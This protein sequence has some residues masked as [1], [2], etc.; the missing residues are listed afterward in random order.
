MRKEGGGVIHCDCC[1]IVFGD[2]LWFWRCWQTSKLLGLGP[3]DDM[4]SHQRYSARSSVIYPHPI[5]HSA[6]TCWFPVI[7]ICVLGGMIYKKHCS[8]FLHIA[9]VNAQMSTTCLFQPSVFTFQLW[10]SGPKNV[11][12]SET[13]WAALCGIG[14]LVS[15]DCSS[16]C[17]CI[18]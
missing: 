16:P 17:I 2:L 15:D 6:M 14:Y 4:L 1:R 3:W 18:I 5:M 12:H 7:T 11:L 10:V 9:H 13:F 8:Y